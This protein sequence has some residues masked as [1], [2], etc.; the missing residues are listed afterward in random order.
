MIE[1]QF[2]CD[3]TSVVR[4]DSISVFFLVCLYKVGILK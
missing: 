1:D 2:K 3:K 4:S